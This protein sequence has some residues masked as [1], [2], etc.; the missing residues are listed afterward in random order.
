MGRKF[1]KKV[2]LW[3]VQARAESMEPRL[4]LSASHSTHLRPGSLRVHPTAAQISAARHEKAILPLTRTTRNGITTDAIFSTAPATGGYLAAQLL[5]SYGLDAVQNMGGNGQGQTIAIIDAANDPNVQTDMTTFD[6]ANGLAAPPNFWVVGQTGGAVPANGAIGTEVETSL[7]VEWAHAVAPK[8]NI[9]LVEANSLYDSDLFG[10]VSWVDTQHTYPNVSVVSMSFGGTDSSGEEAAYNSVFT[11]TGITYLASTGDSGGYLNGT[12]TPGINYPAA[13]PDVLAVGGT[14]LA[15]DAADSVSSEI[16]WGYGTAPNFEGSGGGV[17]STITQPSYQSGVITSSWRTIPDVSFEADP[18]PGVAIC[19]SYDNGSANPWENIGGTSLSAPCW[20]GMIAIINQE[21]VNNGLTALSGSTQTLPM[22]YGLSSSDFR[23][24][25]SGTNGV[26]SAGTGYDLVTGRG[27]PIANRL[28]LDMSGHTT[29]ADLTFSTPSGWSSPLVVTPTSGS[30]VD[31]VLSTGTTLYVDWNGVNDG[32][33]ATSSTFQSRLQVDGVTKQ[34]LTTS[35]PLAANAAFPTTDFSIGTLSA[36][37]HTITVTVN[38]T[39]TQSETDT[40]NNTY[41]RVITV[42]ASTIAD[43]QP[44]TPGG[45]TAPVVATAVSGGT[46][47][48]TLYSS[49]PIYITFAFEN[50][51]ATA[52]SPFYVSFF[53]DGILSAFGELSAASPSSSVGYYYAYYSYAAG[54]FSGGTHTLTLLLNSNDTTTETNYINDDYTRTFTVI[55]SGT[56]TGTLFQDNNS[57]GTLN[58]TDAGLTGQTVYLDINN[59]GVLDSGDISVT[60]T[61][62]GAFTFSNVPVGSYK[63]R[64]VVPTSPATYVQSSP[65]SSYSVTVSTNATSSGFTFGNFLTSYTGASGTNY[66]VQLDG[67]GHTQILVNNVVTYTAPTSIIPSL[68]FNLA[69]GNEALTVSGVNGNPVPTTSGITDNGGTGD[70]LA[71][72]GSSAAYSFTANSGQV[73]FGANAINYNSFSSVSLDPKTGTDNLTVNAGTVNIPAQANGGGFLLRHFANFTIAANA[74]VV[75]GT[76]LSSHADR[77]VL[78]VD[79]SLSINPSGKLDLGGNDMIVRGTGNIGTLFSLLST[80]FNSGAW[81][82]NGIDSSYAASNANHLTALGLL[83]N[84]TG[85]STPIYSTFDGQTGMQAS[86]LLIKYTWYGDANLD[87]IVNGTD[88]SQIDTGYASAGAMTGWSNG[89]FNYDT[90]VD[91]TD[92]SLI[93]NT[94]NMQNGTL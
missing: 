7:D 50:S 78:L 41:T 35:S 3:A 22:L 90:H 38:Y 23:D 36:G 69:A 73:L 64:E 20:A 37:T 24:I 70:S 87:G 29:G 19:D 63:L 62:G 49:S 2:P 13:S 6:T 61:T 85:G 66:Q 28:I 82:G 1:G 30:R 21:R 76:N 42:P 45:W 17:S 39:S 53:L 94:F 32:Q 56:I 68:T 43:L 58:G 92:Y 15:S 44:V 84:N 60:T 52:S 8:A 72:V 16:G 12:S 18:G 51:G 34:T 47:D 55:P 74:A 31:G 91:G 77:S 80:G 9:L 89:D 11:T 4:L 65:A 46:T 79:S 27:V 40:A 75:V 71:L 48:T 88:Y 54:T 57:D 83:A 81:T 26:Y 67:S 33:A 14:T 5:H 25:T 86:D 59:D 10:A 93:D